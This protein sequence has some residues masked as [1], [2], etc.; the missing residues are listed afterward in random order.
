MIHFQ[1]Y[2]FCGR[3]RPFVRPVQLSISTTQFNDS[4]DVDV[5][6]VVTEADKRRTHIVVQVNISCGVQQHFHFGAKKFGELTHFGT[7]TEAP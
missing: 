3:H 1:C 2:V 7:S 6:S 4:V 5:I